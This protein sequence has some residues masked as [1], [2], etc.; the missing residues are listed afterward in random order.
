MK[1]AIYARVST[2][3][4]HNEIQIQERTEYA[5]RR[6]WQLAGVYQD[7]ISGAKAQ[8]PGLDKLMADARLHKFDAVL[9]WK[10]D[11]FG[12]SVIDLVG[13]LRDLESFGVRFVAASQG[14]DTDSANPTSRLL[15]HVLA[16]VAEFE[17]SLIRERVS[18]GLKHAKSKGQ[19][20]GRPRRVFDRQKALDLRQ[21][22]MSYPQIARALGVGQ[23]TVVRAVAKQPAATASR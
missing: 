14:I 8:R 9:V 17:R 10:L 5:E 6:G 23:G 12:R 3:D 7:Q 20:I 13:K 4:Q 21:Q 16:A 15:I 19:R 1:A 22:G 18:A 2:N 11:R